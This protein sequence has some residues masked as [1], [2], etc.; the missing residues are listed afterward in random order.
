MRN[1]QVEKNISSDKTIYEFDTTKFDIAFTVLRLEDFDLYDNLHL[2][3]TPSIKLWELSWDGSSGF[4]QD[5]HEY[6]FI[7]CPPGRFNGED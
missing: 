7:K 3:M 1:Y 4:I 5:K 6:E 2:Y